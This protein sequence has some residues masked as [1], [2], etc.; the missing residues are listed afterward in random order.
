[1]LNSLEKSTILIVDDMPSSI[2][3]LNQILAD[4]Y[5]VLFALDGETALS[6]AR[7]K[8]PELILL[9]VS[10]P[11]MDGYQVC[12]ELKVDPDTRD[13]PVIFVTAKDQD[14]DQEMGFKIGA[15]D[16]LTKPIRPATVKVRVKNQLQIRQSEE[17]ILHQA[18]YDG[19]TK[20]ANR[21]LSMDRLKY[22]IAQDLRNGL[23]T[24]LLFIDLD[25]FKDINDTLGHDAGDQLLIEAATRLKACVRSVDTVG[26]LGGDE[27]VVI[28]PSLE[29]VDDAK[30]VAEN[31]IHI[32]SQPHTLFDI[33]IILTASIGIAISP[34]DSKD[35]KQLLSDADTAMYLSKDSGKNN[36]H[37]FN[38]QMN[39]NVKRRM[40]MEY[41]LRHALDNDELTVYYQPLVN[42]STRKIIGAEALLRWNNAELGSV[43]PDEFIPL[44]EQ[45]GLIEE[46]GA[47]VLKQGCKQ[48]KDLQTPD[49]FAL[50]L[51]INIS[52]QQFRKNN[53]PELVASVIKSTG[54]SATRLELEITEGLLLNNQELIK[55][56]LLAFRQQGIGLSMDDFGTGYSSLSYLRTFPFD[57]IKIDQSFIKEMIANPSD[58]ALVTAAIAMAHALGIKVIAEGVET[59]VQ[60]DFLSAKKCDIAQGYLFSRPVPFEHFKRLLS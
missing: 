48:F 35:Y 34:D 57:T 18:L 14:E 54:F 21:N 8:K 6:I 2:E 4:K 12:R 22:S 28:L 32:F 29:Q 17:I 10:M 51:A 45:T 13:I 41:H 37:L 33:E 52:P 3:I 49:G 30:K 20:L 15:A 24:A 23:K 46:I 19:L 36:Y 50:S 5:R 9:D 60:F 53:L 42:I 39:H 56:S 31:I 27:F 16:Y 1:M 59:E 11:G 25:K 43:S 7:N 26:R 44:A 38:E 47:F 55:K 40:I 58:Q